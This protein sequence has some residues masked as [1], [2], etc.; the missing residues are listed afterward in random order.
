M[1]LVTTSG[2]N[3]LRMDWLNFDRLSDID[4][5]IVTQQSNSL[6]IDVDGLRYAFSGSGVRY[7]SFGEP[8]SGTITG[9][10]VT[11]GGTALFLVS[12]VNVGAG[13]FYQATYAPNDPLPL[14]FGGNDDIRGGTQDDYVYDMFGH[15]ILMGGAG[16]DTLLAGDGNDH[17][18]GASPNGGVD[19][20]D[21]IDGRDGSDYIN[22]NAGN[23]TIYGAGGSDRIQGG[24]DD[25]LLNGGEG[26]DNINGN[27]GNDRIEG[28]FGNDILRGGQ[29][30][31][32]LS[33]GTGN[34]LIMGDLGDDLLTGGAGMDVFVFGPG[35][36]AIG[37]NG[38]RI[39]D[40]EAGIDHIALGFAPRAL[41]VGSDGN[42]SLESA[43]V[44]AQALVDQAPGGDEVA[45]ITAGSTT[46]LFW[47]SGGGATI[48]SMVTL[49]NVGASDFGLTDFI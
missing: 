23:D 35:T 47:A 49:Y 1:V 19:G 34:D 3:A 18:Y 11:Q 20:A 21:H 41:L 25:D 10:T 17:I 4:S 33:G 14:I 48:D 29:G 38:D 45:M 2:A 5:V 46:L 15:N 9:L 44:A 26:H 27:R 43:R 16:R 6:V 7:N 22:G 32:S 24:A 37:A 30:N 12:G 31:D 40:Y 8:V 13:P 36:S 28:D 42:G 39:S